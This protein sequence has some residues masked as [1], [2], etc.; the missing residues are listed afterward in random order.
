MTAFNQNVAAGKDDMPNYFKYSSPISSVEADKS[1]GLALATVGQGVEGLAGLAETTAKDIINKDVR[2]SVEPIREEFTSTLEQARAAQQGNI[3][4]APVQ[5][6]TG[7]QAN[8]R[9]LVM[10]TS[11]PAPAA[12]EAG[13]GKV[14]S[15]QAAMEN[16]KVNDTYYDQRLKAAVTDLR[17]KYPG[18]VDYIDQKVSSIT[19]I[20]P[21]NAY[22]QNLMQDINRAQSNKKT[23]FDKSLDLARGTVGDGMLPNAKEQFF[24]LQK[25]GESYLPAWQNWY[26]DESAKMGAIKRQEVLRKSANMN[27]EDTV[28]QRTSDWELEVG[29]AVHSNLSTLTKISGLSDSKSI[30]DFIADAANNPGKYS[31]DQMKELSTRLIAQQSVLETQLQSRMVQTA[32]DNN[33]KPY[34]Y[35][36]DITSAKAQETIKNNLAVYK[37]MSDALLNKDAG[38]AFYAA[39]HAQAMLDRGKDSLVSDKDVGPWAVKMSSFNTLMG[40]NWTSFITQQATRQ[41]IDDKM[42]AY[43]DNKQLDARLGTAQNMKQNLEEADRLQEHGKITANMKSRYI[44]NLVNLVDDIK[45]PNA[46][47]ADKINVLKHI[48]SPE[49]QGILSHIKTDYVDP[50]TGKA[51]PGK[52]SVWSRLSSQD[53]VDQVGKLAKSDPELGQMYKNYMEREAGKEL[54]QKEFL[55]LNR[56][57]GH[58]DLHFKYNDGGQ[59]GTPQIE[60]IDKSGKPVA[61]PRDVPGQWGLGGENAPAYLRNVDANVQRINSALAGMAR[62]EK[63]LGGNPN[64]YM[65]QFLQRSQVDM[66]KNWEGLPAKLVEAIAASRAPS[67]RIEDTFEDAKGKK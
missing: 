60:L 28:A 59:G 51:V 41:N 38:L 44:G 50:T 13:L 33:G 29:S 61:I 66:G 67:R 39:N 11:T 55:N 64:E 10:N 24:A 6:A 15:I 43:L 46:P 35:A 53:V 3:I 9:T 20:N 32:R 25:N 49:G 17:S 58:D 31:E 22:V 47:D 4:P 16:G 36:T 12:I 27:K 7:S 54:F 42:R 18:F 1:S 8:D 14:Q 37:V 57:T 19:G 2:N 65:L 21:A 30:S 23:E 5:T 48:F 34:S 56:Y 62:V 52:Y 63:G 40:P 45:N 26:A